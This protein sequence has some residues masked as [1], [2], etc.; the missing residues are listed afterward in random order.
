MGR[1]PIGLA[2]ARESWDAYRELND[3]DAALRLDALRRGDYADVPTAAGV[4]CDMLRRLIGEPGGVIEIEVDGVG[5]DVPFWR[6]FVGM[7]LNDSYE[8]YQQIA[9]LNEGERLRD[10]WERLGYDGRISQ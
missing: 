6:H 10:L 5:E 4:A 1:P 2:R 3:M 8:A 9:Q 7:N